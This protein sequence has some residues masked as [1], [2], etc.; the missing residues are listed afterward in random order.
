MQDSTVRMIF[1][2]LAD[3]HINTLLKKYNR[4]PMLDTV[5]VKKATQQIPNSGGVY[6]S[7]GNEKS[8]L[9][10]CDSKGHPEFV[11]KMTGKMEY[12]DSAQTSEVR[13]FLLSPAGN[14]RKNKG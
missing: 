2:P 11:K 10:D 14:T 13:Q 3:V 6:K 5:E 4:P 9:G 12:K 8:F 1:W 7:T